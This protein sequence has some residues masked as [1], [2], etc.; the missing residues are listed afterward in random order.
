MRRIRPPP[1]SSLLASLLSSLLTWLPTWL[2]ASLFTLPWLAAANLADDDTQRFLV[3]SDIHFDPFAD[4]QLFDALRNS[5]AA[6]WPGIFEAGAETGFAQAGSDSNYA[7]LKS[8]LDSARGR[9]PQPEFLLYGGDFLAHDW[10]GRFDALAPASHLDDPAGYRSFTAKT[11]EFLAGM[12]RD[13]FPDTPIFATL[14]NEDSFCGDYQIEP[15]GEFLEAF[16]ESWGPLRGISSHRGH[17]RQGLKSGGYYSALLPSPEKTRL[18]V[19][20]SVYNPEKYTN[21]CGSTR[22]TPALDQMRWLK[23]T[24]RLAERRGEKVW[25]LMH[26]PPGIDGFS[27]E[28]EIAWGGWPVSFWQRELTSRFV[29]LV[30]RYRK[31]I[32]VSFAGHTHMDDYRVIRLGERSLLLN[33]IAP[34]VSP[35]FGNDPG[36]Q[37]FDLSDSH[38]ASSLDFETMRLTNLA[39]AGSGSGQAADWSFE[40]R[41]SQAYGLG[42]LAPSSVVGLAAALA[43][44]G[45]VRDDYQRFYPVGAAPQFDASSIDVYRCAIVNLSVGEFQECLSAEAT[46]GGKAP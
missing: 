42:P 25:F 35:I 27:S 28:R 3:I 14:G 17:G 43:E 5:P 31:R 30:A 45:S 44:E 11:L 37:I 23:K 26:L 38:R 6:L 46:G 29:Q 18:I 19:L 36:Y 33:A 40:Y 41:F 20:N 7:L 16:A 22:Q 2:L 24:L 39:T 8:S 32:Q 9:L 1:L 15:G 34:A 21:P 13:H 4:P 12:F 10:Q